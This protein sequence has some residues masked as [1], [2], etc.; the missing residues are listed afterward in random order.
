MQAYEKQP[1]EY[2]S[3]SIHSHF[4][5]LPAIWPNAKYIHLLR[6]PRDVARSCIGMGWV[7]NVWYGADYWT[8]PEKRWIALTKKVNPESLLEVR[9]EDL[10]CK[11]E[12]VLT[13]ICSF[14]GIEYS[15]EMLKID[16]TSTYARP[17]ASFS[18]Q[19]RTKLSLREVELVEIK[20]KEL[21]IKQGYA[22]SEQSNNHKVSKIERLR[23]YIQ[24]RIVRWSFNSKRW[25]FKLWFSYNL[26]KRIGP[27]MWY[28]R[29][30]NDVNNKQRMYLK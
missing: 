25:G 26:A 4:D 27:R 15:E 10:V 3:G 12:E 24:N 17:D 21:M 11:P 30:Q 28:E 5:E 6:D 20:C 9:Y 18:E 22:I 8:A 16:R 19:W 14:L 29:L 23:L 7:G 2:I 1:N 13:E